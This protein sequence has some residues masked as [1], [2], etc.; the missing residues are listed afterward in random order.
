MPRPNTA[1]RH[2]QAGQHIL[3]RPSDMENAPLLD[4]GV[5]DRPAEQQNTVNRTDGYDERG[6]ARVVD[7]TLVTDFVE[8]WRIN[9]RNQGEQVKRLFLA[10]QEP[11]EFTRD[12]TAVVDQAYVAR[13]GH[14]IPLVLPAGHDDEGERAF[15]VSAVTVTDGDAVTY[16]EGTDYIVD[17]VKGLILIMEGGAIEDLDPIE[18]SYTPEEQVGGSRILPQTMQQGVECYAEVWEVASSGND[19]L[20]RTIPRALITSSGARVMG[21]N[22]FNNIELELTVLADL[23]AAAP[24]GEYMHVKGGKGGPGA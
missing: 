12:D 7:E 9:T 5:L 14:W 23:N 2:R 15:N 4:I 10:A 20:V 13:V 16:T 17:A 22:V 6:G 21:L 11:D 18:V 24:A 3:V 19:Q 1:E 8:R